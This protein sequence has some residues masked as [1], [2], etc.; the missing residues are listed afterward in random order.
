MPEASVTSCNALLEWYRC[1]F[2]LVPPSRTKSIYPLSHATSTTIVYA[3][4][5]CRL[6]R[7][8]CVLASALPRSHNDDY[9]YTI[10]ESSPPPVHRTASISGSSERITSFLAINRLIQKGNGQFELACMGL[11]LF[12]KARTAQN[13]RATGRLK[14]NR[15]GR[16]TFGTIRLSFGA[17]P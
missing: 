8:A 14:R 13:R 17:Y 1:I 10:G 7:T 5:L 4:S 6:R 9:P 2:S 3:D 11:K 12:L 15:C 16:S